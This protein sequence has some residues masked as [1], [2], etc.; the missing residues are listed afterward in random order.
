MSDKSASRFPGEA[1]PP[2]S[3]GAWPILMRIL[4]PLAGLAAHT[5]QVN[6]ARR[7]VGRPVGDR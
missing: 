5:D 3:W 2:D 1:A 6:Y 7:Q 4:R